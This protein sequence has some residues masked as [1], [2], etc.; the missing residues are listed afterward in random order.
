[1]PF[2]HD[3]FLDAT[4]PT[5]FQLHPPF[6]FIL[7]CKARPCISTAR[8][9]S[10]PKHPAFPF[11]KSMPRLFAPLPSCPAIPFIFNVAKPANER[12]KLVLPQ[13]GAHYSLSAWASSF[14]ATALFNNR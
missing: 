8:I 3:S 4:R 7:P 11:V 13:S 9:Y 2:T 6:P 1:M 12:Q 10:I 14:A 5:F